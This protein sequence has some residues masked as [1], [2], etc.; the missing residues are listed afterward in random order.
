MQISEHGVYHKEEV[1][2][3]RKLDLGIWVCFYTCR[4]PEIGDKRG[5]ACQSHDERVLLI[6]GKVFKASFNASPDFQLLALEQFLLGSRVQPLELQGGNRMRFYCSRQ[7]FWGYIVH[8]ATGEMAILSKSSMVLR[9]EPR[10]TGSFVMRSDVGLQGGL[11]SL[12]MPLQGR[13]AR[14]SLRW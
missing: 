2:T 1:W 4:M 10:R 12:P 8:H 14:N 5:F 9:G 13:G 7:R 6:R 11:G 3:L